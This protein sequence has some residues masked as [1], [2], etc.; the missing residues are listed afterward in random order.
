MARFKKEIKSDFTVIH[1]AFVCDMN[2]GINA[3]GILITIDKFENFKDYAENY[4]WH[5]LRKNAK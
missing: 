3:L 2:L 5:K 4:K 1:N